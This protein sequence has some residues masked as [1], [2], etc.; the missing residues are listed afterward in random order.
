MPQASLPAIFMYAFIIVFF[1]I[2]V[3]SENYFSLH[4]LIKS[5]LIFR[6]IVT[7]IYL[8]NTIAVI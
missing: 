7:Y 1:Y 2:Y 6:I 8:Q 3:N 4:F 5:S